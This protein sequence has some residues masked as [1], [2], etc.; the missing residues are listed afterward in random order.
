MYKTKTYHNFILKLYVIIYFINIFLVPCHRYTMPSHYKGPCPIFNLAGCSNPSNPP[1]CPILDS[2]PRIPC[3]S[4]RCDSSTT[5]ATPTTQVQRISDIF[6]C[7]S[8]HVWL[9]LWTQF[10]NG[11][12]R[13]KLQSLFLSQFR[14]LESLESLKEVQSPLCWTTWSL[15]EVQSTL[16]WTTCQ[17]LHQQHFNLFLIPLKLEMKPLLF[18]TC[19]YFF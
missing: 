11:Q 1:G 12:Q 8:C 15:K 3:F 4:W 17:V 7:Q 13:L 16:C 9:T 5:P 18:L 6:L 19:K 10:Q 14:H 2:R